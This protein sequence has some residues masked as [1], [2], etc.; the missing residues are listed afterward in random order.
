M[1]LRFIDRK[2]GLY[3]PYDDKRDDGE[4]YYQDMENVIIESQREYDLRSNTSQ[5]TPNT[6]TSDKS[7]Q[8][9]IVSKPKI[10]KQKDKTVA[11]NS[12]KGKEKALKTMKNRVQ[13]L[14][15]LTLQ[16]VLLL[17]PFCEM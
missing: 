4:S 11:G 13:T 8:N 15:V 1:N 6:K 2:Q 5:K 16:L 12:N 10:V 17:K 3:T 7:S 9:N 14:A